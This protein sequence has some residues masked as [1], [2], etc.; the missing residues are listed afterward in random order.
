[1]PSRATLDALPL[2]AAIL[3]ARQEQGA[4]WTP[5]QPL[6]GPQTRALETEAD[7]LFYGG[8]AGGGKSSL[9][10]GLAFTQHRRSAIFR[11]EYKELRSLVEDSR[12]LAG[13]HGS[14]NGQDLVWRMADGRLV[15]FGAVQYEPD[16]RKWRGRPH[17]L[18]AFDELGEFTE[19]QYLFLTAWAR[20]TIPGQRVRIVGAGNPPGTVE[21]EWVI[22]RW[23]PWLD[24]QHPNPAEPGELRWFAMVDHGD[25][26][27]PVDTECESGRPFEWKGELLQP[28]SRTFIPARLADNPHLD[29]GTYR[30]RLQA[31]PEPLRSQLL[32]GDFSIGLQDDEWQVIPTAWVQQAQ[33]RWREDGRPT[34]E[35]G[36]PVPATAVG[37]DVA[38]GGA[39][40]TVL[41]RR[42][43]SW[44][45]RP[46]VHPG[47][48]TPD[49]DLGAGLVLAALAEGG[50]AT[51]DANGIGA[52]TYYLLRAKLRDRARAF[53]GSDPTI[54]KD[55]SGTLSFVNVRAA[56]WWAFREALDPAGGQSIALPPGRELRA[57]LCAPRWK[58]LTSGVQLESKD[59]TKTRL[60]RSPDLADAV[61]MAWWTDPRAGWL[62]VIGQTASIGAAG[63]AGQPAQDPRLPP[64]P[65]AGQRD[66]YAAEHAR[67]DQATRRGGR[68]GGYRRW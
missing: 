36:T 53:V 6:P 2:A 55:K 7:E 59:D 67:R 23:A 26:N 9:L 56:A 11:R 10:L 24:G 5:W 68:G 41:A 64:D 51:I 63:G 38:G 15:E 66:Y 52:S 4:E 42:Y 39:D 65:F 13:D 32:Y 61:V 20:T 3:A 1:V 14:F 58:P 25:G 45:A 12:E 44:Y 27:G 33:G 18:K 57:E 19:S 50:Y 8:Q 47:S 35:R 40:R 22:H 62:A 29:G 31:Q 48:S 17:D 60:G 21:G 49:A 43:G 37:V 30:A 34:D 54:V 28:T 16:V 46:E